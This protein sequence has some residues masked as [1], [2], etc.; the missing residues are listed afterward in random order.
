MRKIK[1]WGIS[2]GIL[3][4]VG[5]LIAWNVRSGQVG[6]LADGTTRLIS[7]LARATQ[8]LWGGGSRWVENYAVLRGVREENRQLKNEVSQ[9]QSRVLALSEENRGAQRNERLEAFGNSLG[10]GG[11]VA[12]VV[13]MDPHKLRRSLTINRGSRH[14]VQ[15]GQTVSSEGGLV[16]RVIQVG[17]NSAVV[18]LITDMKSTVDVMGMR[19]RARG[20]LR[21]KRK[22]LDLNRQYWLT[23]AEYF[24]GAQELRPGD[25]LMTSG[26]DG[27]FPKGLPVGEVQSFEKEVSGFFYQAEVSPYVELSKL[28]EVWVM[29]PEESPPSF[30]AVEK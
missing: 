21:G 14:G 11:Q 17:K 12:Q 6:W 29:G 24:K 2:L 25:I 30:G 16:G 18:L 13:G 27:V 28:E 4:L 9:L 3:G 23:Q 10:S 8:N 15:V 22:S 5:F 20:T 7:P 19:T 26:L 1:F